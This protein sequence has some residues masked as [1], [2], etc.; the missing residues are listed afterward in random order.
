VHNSLAQNQT[1]NEAS[2]TMASI[3][4]DMAILKNRLKN[5]REEANSKF[6]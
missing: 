2:E 5:L 1:A 6:K 3:E 4:E